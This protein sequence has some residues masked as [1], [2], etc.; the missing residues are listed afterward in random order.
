MAAVTMAAIAVLLATAQAQKTALD[1]F[2][3]VALG[4]DGSLNR[5]AN[6]AELTPGE[7]ET[8]SRLLAARNEKRR[9]R[10]LEQQKKEA[11][12]ALHRRIGAWLSRMLK[13]ISGRPP[14]TMIDF[15]PDFVRAI[16]EG[17][18]RATTRYVA[19]GG[20]PQ[21]AALRAGHRVSATC[22]R[23]DDDMLCHPVGP[24]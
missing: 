24:R 15:A 16:L 4:K 12:P 1:E 19:A 6:W 7:R 3:P 22:V 8:A 17:T 11:R 13:R 21:L 9:K 14:P 23:C 5:V 20:E 2:G 10:L 18:K